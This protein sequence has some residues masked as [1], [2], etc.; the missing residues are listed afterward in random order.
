MPGNVTFHRPSTLEE[1]LSLLAADPQESKLLAGGTAFTILWRSGL[2]QAEHVV[3]CAGVTN[4]TTSG[5]RTAR[6]CSAPWPLSGR[7]R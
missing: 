3:C 1:T 6:P 7:P 2:I 4:S 5:P